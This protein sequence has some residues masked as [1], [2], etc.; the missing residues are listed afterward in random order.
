MYPHIRDISLPPPF[1]PLHPSPPQP[2]LAP[3]PHT[4]TPHVPRVSAAASLTHPNA[5]S[6]VS[7]QKYDRH[8]DAAARGR[9][10]QGGGAER[11]ASTRSKGGRHGS[12]RHL[13]RSA[14]CTHPSSG[15]RASQEQRLLREELMSLRENG[16][17]SAQ[18]RS[19][20]ADTHSALAVLPLTT[21]FFFL[22]SPQRPRE[23]QQ[24][25]GQDCQTGARNCAAQRGAAG[26][27]QNAV[28]GQ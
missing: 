17:V 19:A 9:G 11:G 14:S 6:P 1:P 23:R 21:F 13:P 4:H 8:E 7:P 12:H 28:I 5:A 2:S 10:R 20:C 3:Q 16:S 27:L 25:C 24:D 26:A 18:S 15:L 22:L